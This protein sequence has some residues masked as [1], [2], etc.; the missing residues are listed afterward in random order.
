MPRAKPEPEPEESLRDIYPP[1]LEVSELEIRQTWLAF[2]SAAVSGFANDTK[3][4]EDEVADTSCDIADAMLEE[5]MARFDPAWEEEEEEEEE[6]TDTP[7]A[8]RRSRR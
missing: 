7:A 6:E 5:Y 1:T 8:R 2:A 3:M 4:K